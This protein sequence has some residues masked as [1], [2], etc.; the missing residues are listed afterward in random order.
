MYIYHTLKIDIFTF[1]NVESF[2]YLDSILNADNKMNIE[3]YET[4]AK[5]NK[6]Y[7]ANSKLKIETL[8]EKH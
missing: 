2:N 1:E 3:N 4:I 5:E 8:K 7:Y 6:A